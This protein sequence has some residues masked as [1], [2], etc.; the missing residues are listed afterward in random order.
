MCSYIRSNQ[1]F[2]QV[3]LRPAFRGCPF[4][5]LY[6]PSNVSLTSL[7]FVS[8]VRAIVPSG[9]VALHVILLPTHPGDVKRPYPP[10]LST[11]WLIQSLS[12]GSQVTQ[13]SPTISGRGT[14]QRAGKHNGLASANR[15]RPSCMC[16]SPCDR[17]AGR[18]ESDDRST[19]RVKTA[20]LKSPAEYSELGSA[21]PPSRCQPLVMQA[22]ERLH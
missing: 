4:L 2:L 13:L 12:V 9:F 5:S 3:W 19:Y 16:R 1:D 6:R 8:T 21:A 15:R 10:K 20:W 14:C 22:Q 11:F 7:I 17:Q 18:G